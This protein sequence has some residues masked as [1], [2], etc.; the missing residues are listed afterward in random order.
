MFVKRVDRHFL[1]DPQEDQECRRQSYHE[2]GN[3]ECAVGFVLD[4]IPQSGDHVTA[5]QRELKH[6]GVDQLAPKFD[7]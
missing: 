5:N 3:I 7:L 4:Q 2:S 1:V 6:Q